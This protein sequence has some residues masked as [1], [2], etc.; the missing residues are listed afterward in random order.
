M[1]QISKGASFF[2]KHSVSRLVMHSALLIILTTLG[3]EHQRY[4]SHCCYCRSNSNQGGGGGDG[5]GCG[6]PCNLISILFTTV[7]GIILVPWIF[8]YFVH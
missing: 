2:T 4:C 8:C 6:A 7:K 3:Q 1:T 5:G